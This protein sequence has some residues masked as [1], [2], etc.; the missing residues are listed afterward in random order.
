ME[1]PGNEHVVGGAEPNDVVTPFSHREEPHN[2]QPLTGDGASPGKIFIGGLARETTIAQ[3]I[4][5]FGK[6]GEITDSVIMKDRKTG[7]P[8]GFGFITYADPSVVDKVIEDPHIINGKQVEIKRTIPRGAVGSKDFRTKKIFVGGIPSNVTE[9]EFRDFFTRYG[10]VKDHQIMRDHSTNRSRGFGFITFDTEEAVDDLLSMGNK[11]EFAG[12]QVEIKKAEP[13][14]PNS[15]PPSSKRYNDSRSSYSSGY[16]D[17]YDGFGGSFGVGGGYRSGGAYGG[18]RGSG[19]YGGYGS[20]FGGYGGYVGAMGPY[21]GDPSLGYAGRYGGSFSRGYD[22]GGYSG[23]SENY[24]AY[25]GGGGGGGGSSGGGGAYQSGY[26][27]NL[28]GGYGGASGGPF[29]GSSR[30][31]YGAGRYHPYGR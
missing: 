21:R 30:G 9:D 8:R 1:S 22:L 24:G 18:G 12:A 2:S 5:H 4:K 27:G 17:T 7:Q 19:A 13:K 29:Y 6:Y 15:A 11:I 14:K 20:E 3:F 23:P 16:G 25:G 28:G 26:D 10:E 31:G